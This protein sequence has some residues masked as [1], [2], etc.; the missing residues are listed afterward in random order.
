MEALKRVAETF[1]DVTPMNDPKI[2]HASQLLKASE[3][4]AR[5]SRFNGK[6]KTRRAIQHMRR[7][8][9]CASLW[10][11]LHDGQVSPMVLEAAV[12]GK[13]WDDQLVYSRLH[14]ACP[15]IF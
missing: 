1:S 5:L 15:S 12:Y 8:A 6:D 2:Q 3:G 14:R 11:G 9:E 4:F 7:V 10:A 13:D